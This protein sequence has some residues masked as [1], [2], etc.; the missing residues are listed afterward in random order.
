MGNYG[1]VRPDKEHYRAL[2]TPV[3]GASRQ[4]TSPGFEQNENSR[5]QWGY[6]NPLIH[7]LPCRFGRSNYFLKH[8]G[9]FYSFAKH[10]VSHRILS[11][12]S[13]RGFSSRLLSSIPELPPD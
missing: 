8:R 6:F 3:N 1:A 11:L 13:F 7:H 10:Q 5:T 2:Q 9:V 12:A 4:F